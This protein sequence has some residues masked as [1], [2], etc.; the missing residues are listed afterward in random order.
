MMTD[1]FE[2]L[3]KTY[4]GFA[5]EIFRANHLL[6]I[7]VGPCSFRDALISSEQ[8]KVLDEIRTLLPEEVKKSRSIRK[9]FQ[10]YDLSF[11]FGDENLCNQIF[12]KM[13]RIIRNAK[14]ITPKK[15]KDRDSVSIAM[16]MHFYKF[17]LPCYKK[18]Q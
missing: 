11:K 15:R 17:G 13:A 10:L 5:R 2:K 8:R 14:N 4:K 12:E 6:P 7:R 9:L 18:T 3:Y 16:G 1:R